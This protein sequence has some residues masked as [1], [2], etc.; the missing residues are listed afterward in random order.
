[1]R[2]RRQAAAVGRDHD[3]GTLVALGLAFAAAPFFAGENVPSAI[4]CSVC[5]TPTRSNARSS[6]DQS[7]S[8]SPLVVQAWM[9]PQQVAGDGN[10]GDRFFQRATR[11]RIHTIPSKQRRASTGGRPPNSDRGGARN[12]PSISNHCS[13][14]S[15][16]LGSLLVSCFHSKSCSATTR[17][18]TSSR[19][20]SAL[21]YCG[22]RLRLQFL[23][24]CMR[25][26]AAEAMPKATL[27]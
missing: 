20:S 21:A 17:W 7:C 13:S 6:R 2:G 19:S 8:H 22:I 25:L 11:H 18:A 15:S 1:M 24:C 23:G 27:H 26:T 14:V 4:A 10:R 16:R 9:R 3:L 12:K 5:T